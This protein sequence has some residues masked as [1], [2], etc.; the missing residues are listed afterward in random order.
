MYRYNESYL[1]RNYK[2]EKARMPTFDILDTL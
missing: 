2:M 1:F